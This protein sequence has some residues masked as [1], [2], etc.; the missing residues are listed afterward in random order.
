MTA[1]YRLRGL[2]WFL[3]GVIVVLG[4]YL[5]SLQVAAERKKV[6]DVERAIIRAQRDIRQLETEFATRANMDQLQ[7]WNG[8]V[9]AL[10][11]PTADQFVPDDVALA[12]VS[13]TG[14][15]GPRQMLVPSA[16]AEPAIQQ[17]IAVAPAAAP[18]PA[19]QIAAA[20]AAPAPA[21]APAQPPRGPRAIMASSTV[22]VAAAPM[23]PAAR[24]RRIAML[25]RTILRERRI[26]DIIDTIP[27]DQGGTR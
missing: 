26:G 21:P 10:A 14:G 23:P 22:A 8:E 16:P 18:A 11:A 24:A 2:G 27:L 19:P 3:S 6:A 1:A 20:Q 25:D 7:K 4:C 12:Q 9:F 13:F 5:V 17:A 15:N